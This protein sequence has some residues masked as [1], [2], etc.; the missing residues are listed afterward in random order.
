MTNRIKTFS[1]PQGKLA[2]WLLHPGGDTLP[3]IR[4]ALVSTLFGTLPIFLGGVFNTI[5]VAW[6]LEYRHPSPLFH[7]WLAS[8]IVV[9]AVRLA[10]LLLAHRRARQGKPTPTDLYILLAP[11]WG[12]TV[13]YGALISSI[14]GDWVAATLSFLSAAAMVGGICF[15]NFAAPRLV[16]IMIFLS[17]GPCCVGAVLSG[18]PVLLL[19]LVQIPFY[20]FAMS[21]AARKLN[22]ML[23]TTM[24]AERENDRRARHDGLTGLLNRTGLLHATTHELAGSHRIG[25]GVPLFYIDLDGFKAVNDTHGHEFGDMLLMQVAA[26]LRQ[27]AGH[28]ALVARMGG[29]EFVIVGQVPA[30]SDPDTFAS[31]VIGEIEKPFRLADDVVVRIGA[32]IGIASVTDAGHGIDK[33]VRSA[34]VAM[35]EAKR[36]K[37][38]HEVA[39]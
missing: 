7:F 11:L 4:I 10:V 13:G 16:A 23:I 5:A 25:P 30:A 15:R 35:Y 33:V 26:K 6:V 34:D 19:T 22:A 18:E 38:K 32:S 24:V 1:L 2:N 3:E 17:L 9:C 29:D 37:K 31:S 8:E 39:A 36:H 21:V 14:S 20:L 27:L 28:D 12:A